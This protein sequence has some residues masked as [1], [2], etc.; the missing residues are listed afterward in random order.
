MFKVFV[1]GQH[2]TTGLEIH[3]LLAGRAEL[4]LLEVAAADK[5]DPQVRRTLLNEADAVVLCL[6]DDAAIE[7]VRLIESPD[8]RVLDAST[9]HRTDASWAYG[10]PEL[11]TQRQRLAGARRVSNPGCYPT[12]F[13]LAVRP[14][15]DAGVLPATVPLSVHAVSGYSGGGRQMIE[16]FEARAGT[17]NSPDELFHAQ[18]Y[19]LTLK[20]KHVPEMQRHSGTTAAPL[21]T[22]SVGHFHRGMLVCVPL[23]VGSLARAVSRDDVR[24]LWADAYT[25]EACVSVLPHDAALDGGYLDPQGANFGNQ[26]EL[27]VFGNAEQLLLVARLDNLGKGA[28]GAAVQNLNLMLGLPELAGVPMRATTATGAAAT[29]AAATGAAR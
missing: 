25:G 2:G 14:L 11:P 3:R 13:V 24:A 5:K 18:A 16:K 4:E 29:G 9:A 12:G 20:H 10:L 26:V 23:F 21:F 19:G 15:I 6:P 8:V 27:M 22:P 7:A 1:D 17:A 28:A